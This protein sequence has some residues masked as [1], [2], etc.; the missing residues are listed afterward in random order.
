MRL[1]RLFFLIAVILAML[2][3]V[4]Q[5][6]REFGEVAS[7]A[8]ERETVAA[9]SSDAAPEP[10]SSD[11]E[12]NSSVTSPNSQETLDVPTPVI[13]VDPLF[14]DSYPVSSQI[15]L[16][17]WESLQLPMGH[18]DV[19][20]AESISHPA[21]RDG[22]TTI[23]VARGWTGETQMGMRLQD[24]FLSMCGLIIARANVVQDRP[25]VARIVHP[26]LLRSGWVARIYPGDL[27]ACEDPAMSAWAIVPGNP[28]RLARLK[29]THNV[30]GMDFHPIG[31]LRISSQSDVTSET[32]PS[33]EPTEISITVR[34]ANMRRCAS[35]ECDIV[36]KVDGGDYTAALI[37]D[38]GAWTLAT[39][40]NNYGWIF[41]ELYRVL[42]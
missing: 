3:L 29:V 8:P 15:P 5:I 37:E 41:N 14:V 22:Q 20:A 31:D 2:V 23:L 1:S 30:P 6:F 4:W 33:P 10:M 19:L 38:T 32:Y 9:Q 42:E 24:V 16:D 17:T 34:R 28:A 12:P 21:G 26:N 25:D 35:T 36:G 11:G 7:R 27:P 40:D 13:E 39:I 18:F